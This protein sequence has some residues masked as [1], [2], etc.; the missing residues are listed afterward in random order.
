MKRSQHPEPIKFL[1]ATL[2]AGSGLAA[3]RQQ[4]YQQFRRTIRTLGPIDKATAWLS[5][6]ADHRETDDDLECLIYLSSRGHS[7]DRHVQ[8][9]RAEWKLAESDSFEQYQQRTA[10]TA[11]DGPVTVED[12]STKSSFAWPNFWEGHH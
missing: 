7:I 6:R 10:T 11:D 9:L 3:R 1:K 2:K 12:F 5:Y 4:E 8:Q